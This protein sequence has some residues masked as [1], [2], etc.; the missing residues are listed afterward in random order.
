MPQLQNMTLTDRQTPTPVAHS[1][2]PRDIVNGVGTVI[3]STGIPI[4]NNRVSVSLSKTPNGKYK[5]KITSAFPVVQ[6][7]TINGVSTPVV[8]RTHYADMTFTFDQSSS[9]SERDSF[10]G[11]M[12]D[13]LSVTNPLTNDVLVKLQGVY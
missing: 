5:A 9:T 3:E 1:F 10:I 11:M 2:T 6:T 7:Q 8:V 13:A 12:R 4:G